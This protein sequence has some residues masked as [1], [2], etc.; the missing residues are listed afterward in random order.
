[1]GKIKWLGILALAGGLCVL[2]YQ[3]IEY[4]MSEGTVFKN[5]TLLGLFGE[6]LLEWIDRAPVQLRNGIDYVIRM[7]LYGLLAIIGVVLLAINGVFGKK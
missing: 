1:M 7:P 4:V 2:G 3:G 5:Y 6:S